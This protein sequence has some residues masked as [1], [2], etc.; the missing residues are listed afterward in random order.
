LLSVTGTFTIARDALNN[1]PILKLSAGALTGW[2]ATPA[3]AFQ[4]EIVHT[5]A[6][7]SGLLTDFTIDTSSF[8]NP[9]NAGFSFSL[10]TQNS[11]NDLFVQY[12]PVPEPAHVLVV[13]LAA[14]TLGRAARRRTARM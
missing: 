4:W 3:S 7:I 11:G 5:T 8:S 2:S 12:S 1:K 10:F 13:G 6:G 14:L 9:T